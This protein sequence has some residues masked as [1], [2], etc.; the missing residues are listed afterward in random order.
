[1]GRGGDWVR[2]VAMRERR[3]EELGGR[4]GRADRVLEALRMDGM[5]E[6]VSHTY[7]RGKY[8]RCVGMEEMEIM[9]LS[10]HLH[11]CSCLTSG[12]RWVTCE[13]FTGRVLC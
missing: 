1:M 8:E 4:G 5:V 10:P 9:E 11:C 12:G 6:V 7:V 3:E 13:G 2:R